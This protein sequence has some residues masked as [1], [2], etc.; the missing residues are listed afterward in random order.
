MSGNSAF[1]DVVFETLRPDFESVRHDLLKSTR[2]LCP[3]HSQ[4]S[5]NR[6]EWAVNILYIMDKK[7]KCNNNTKKR[8]LM[9]VVYMGNY[10]VNF[11]MIYYYSAQ[12]YFDLIAP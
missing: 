3:F 5:I 1:I 11:F 12:V 10:S 8:A 9:N 6:I 7:N 4:A 2:D